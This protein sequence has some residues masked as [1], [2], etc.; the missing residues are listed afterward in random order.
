MRVAIA[1]QQNQIRQHTIA[2][3]A[4]GARLDVRPINAT[5]VPFLNVLG[6]S[7]FGRKLRGKISPPEAVLWLSCSLFDARLRCK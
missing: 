4:L 6:D 3:D 2:K 5:L 7:F 1:L